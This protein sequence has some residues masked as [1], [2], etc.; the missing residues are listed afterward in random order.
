[1]VAAIHKTMRRIDE[2]HDRRDGC[3][4]GEARGCDKRQQGA[5]TSQ[6]TL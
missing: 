1:M 4:S 5:K 6:S 2:L 3:N